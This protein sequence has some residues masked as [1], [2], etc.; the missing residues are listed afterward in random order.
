[1]SR[2]VA[3]LSERLVKENKESQRK[4]E[5]KRERDRKRLKER[6][7]EKRANNDFQNYC[8]IFMKHIAIIAIRINVMK[9]VSFRNKEP[10]FSC[11]KAVNELNE[12]KR[13]LVFLLL[14]FSSETFESIVFNCILFFENVNCNNSAKLIYFFNKFNRIFTE[15]KK[16]IN[17]LLIIR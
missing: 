16:Y 1:M 2:R 4:G 3:E 14:I 12:A 8:F 7:K 17:C 11:E 9:H 5:G 6:R 10:N 15:V 13:R